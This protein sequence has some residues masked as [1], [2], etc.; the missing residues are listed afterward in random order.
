MGKRRFAFACALLATL[1]SGCTGSSE[2]PTLRMQLPYEPATLDHSLAE[3]GASFRVLSALM[4]GLV[5]YDRNYGIKL[6]I[7]E[8]M[9]KL[10]GGK[11]YRFNLRPWKWSDGQEVTAADFVFAFRRTLE[12]S[13]PAKLGDLLFFIKNARA[14]KSGKITDFSRV[15]VSAPSEK[16]LEFSLEGASSVFP[17]VLTLPIG[18]PQRAD[19]GGRGPLR[20]P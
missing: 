13:T 2:A 20:S 11:R 7:A 5:S 18:L 19:S 1:A 6:E 10:D 12:P 3:D 17:H 4:T 14:Y 16:T 9:E 15:G 8:S